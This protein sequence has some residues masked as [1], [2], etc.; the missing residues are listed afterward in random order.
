MSRAGGLVGVAVAGLW[1]R[2]RRVLLAAAGVALAVVLVVTLTGLGYGLF[3]TGGEAIEWLDRD[4]WATGGAVTFAPGAV[5]NVE[6]PIT[7][8]HRVSEEIESRPEVADAQPLAFQSVYVSPNTSE[9]TSVVGVGAGNTSAGF[10]DDES[11]G[12]PL[13]SGGLAGDVHY[14][15]GSYDGRMTHE[16]VINTELARQFDVSVGDTL[17]V[18]GT[19]A[20]ARANEFTVVGVHTTFSTFLGAPTAAMPLSELQEISGTTGNDPASIIGITTRPSAESA[21]VA[22]AIE[23]DHPSLSVN[24]NRE[25]VRSIVGNQTG[26]AVGAIALVVLVLVAGIALV[27]NVLGLWVYA[28]RTELAALK[29]SG[30]SGRSLLAVVVAQGAFV[31][32]VGGAVGL[33]ASLPAVDFVNGVA[34]DVS[35]FVDLIKTPPWVFGVGGGIA[36]G[37]GV[38][39]AFV[40]GYRVVRLS[41]LAHLE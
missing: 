15:N 19:L 2:R 41:P 12:V 17:Y 26:A 3:S 36:V 21:A 5:G 25:Q 30:V 32:A 28:Q 13:G 23:R 8:A 34:A 16:V 31:G 29:A 18:G 10:G 9:F 1:H 7:D 4:F 39:G 37:M 24:T 35:G 20:T 38:V 11:K 14:A 22:T 40:A 33:A 6:N 27:T